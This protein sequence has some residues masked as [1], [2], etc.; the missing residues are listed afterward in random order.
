LHCTNATFPCLN[1]SHNGH[2]GLPLARDGDSVANGGR[3]T[4]LD[5]A[6]PAPEACQRRLAANIL[7]NLGFVDFCPGDQAPIPGA[8]PS[9]TASYAIF[10]RSSGSEA[11]L[12]CVTAAA[13]R[14]NGALKMS[15]AV[16][17]HL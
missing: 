13:M 10:I 1:R 15:D 14:F 4:P 9:S 16:G 8:M 2:C 11:A 17:V 7:K 12:W 6:D 5:T 3:Q